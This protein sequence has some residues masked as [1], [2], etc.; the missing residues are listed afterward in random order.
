MTPSRKLLALSL[1]T[2]VA[3]LACNNGPDGPGRLSV[4]LT[5][6][7]APA[8][9]GVWVNVTAVRAHHVSSGWITLS[10][11]PVR[12]NLLALQDHVLDLGLATLPPGV[13]TQLRLVVEE[14]GNVVIQGTSELP[15]TVPSGSESGIKIQGPWEID[16]CTETALALELDGDR[17]VVYHPTGSGEWILRPVVRTVR[18][19]SLPVDCEPPPATCVPAE[20]G[21]GACA[22]SGDRC[23]PGGASTP[24]SA[25]AD[26][27]SG[28]CLTALCAPGP[29]GAACNVTADCVAGLSCFGGLCAASPEAL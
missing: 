4:A 7:S 23:V 20:C 6:V 22:V 19:A 15:L 2:A 12:V 26:C 28:V 18:V 5:A 29:V 14:E 16:D 25:A 1:L 3:T 21:S 27:L 8:A 17:S 24:C 11:A 13:V 9:D 10:E